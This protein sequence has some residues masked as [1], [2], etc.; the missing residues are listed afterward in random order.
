VLATLG[1]WYWSQGSISVDTVKTPKVEAFYWAAIMFSQTLGTAL[2][3][4]MADDTGLGYHGS[5][6]LI[7]AAL[8]ILGAL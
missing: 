6:L 1:L 2:G 8:G 3:D 4:W 5:A 7:A